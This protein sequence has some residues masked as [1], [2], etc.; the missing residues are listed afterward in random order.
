MKLQNFVDMLNTNKNEAF[1]FATPVLGVKF[2]C[3]TNGT[4]YILRV[5]FLTPFR[6][7]PYLLLRGLRLTILGHNLE[8]YENSGKLS[9]RPP[10]AKIITLLIAYRQL[11][12]KKSEKMKIQLPSLET[13]K[14]S[15]TRDIHEILLRQTSALLYLGKEPII[16]RTSNI[17]MF[18][19]ELHYSQ[20]PTNY[21][22]IF[23]ILE[24]TNC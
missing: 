10:T 11:R 21:N 23:I 19:K 17:L 13:L 14:N 15:K 7:S 4:P 1:L 24:K 5:Q 6:G 20:R 22:S 9:G 8:K 12:Q 2:H 3:F 18:E 16:Q